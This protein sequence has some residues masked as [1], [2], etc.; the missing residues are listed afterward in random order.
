MESLNHARLIILRK[1]QQLTMFNDEIVSAEEKTLANN[2]HGADTEKRQEMAEKH[3]CKFRDDAIKVDQTTIKT[4]EAVV[5]DKLVK[6]L[7]PL[8]R[9]L[10]NHS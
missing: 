3:S 10:P 6:E 2:V 4:K 7:N 5:L 8:S 1:V 9:C